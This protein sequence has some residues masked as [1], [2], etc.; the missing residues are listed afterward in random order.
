M[1]IIT[2]SHTHTKE[3]TRN[4]RG[5]PY[6]L[7]VTFNKPKTYIDGYCHTSDCGSLVSLICFGDLFDTHEKSALLF[8]KAL[9][10]WDSNV[11]IP[12]LVV[13]RSPG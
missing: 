8:E 12:S 1:L 7:V 6:V 13:Y 2:F 11:I 5:C 4:L 10:M 3:A 9:K